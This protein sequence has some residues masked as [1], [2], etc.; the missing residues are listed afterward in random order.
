MKTEPDYSYPVNLKGLIVGLLTLLVVLGCSRR[1]SPYAP[2]FGVVLQSDELEAYLQT[3]EEVM[4]L[5]FTLHWDTSQVRVGDPRA[6]AA[7]AKQLVRFRR[8]PGAMK[9]L[10]FSLQGEPISHDPPPVLRFP[11]QVLT[12][13]RTPNF[14]LS[15]VVFSRRRG[16]VLKLPVHNWPTP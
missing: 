2:G 9:V 3:P 8:R 7:N 13:G 5:E 10:M 4:G 6:T 15:D 16:K 11:V 12:A 1:S 14:Q